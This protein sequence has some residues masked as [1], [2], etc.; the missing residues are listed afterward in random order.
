MYSDS[1]RGIRRCEVRFLMGTRNILLCSTLVTRRKTSSFNRVLSSLLSP[2]ALAAMHTI[3]VREHNRIALELREIN[4]HWDK[5]RLFQETR[6]II[7]A[8]MQHISYSEYLPTIL[9]K[10]MVRSL[11]KL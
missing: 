7:G 8:M 4:P 5:E 10:Q 9:S 2:K 3:W 6:K 11:L 1:E